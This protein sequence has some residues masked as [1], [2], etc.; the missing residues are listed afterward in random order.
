MSQ[1]GSP[2]SISSRRMAMPVHSVSSHR[3]VF[4]SAQFITVQCARFVEMTREWQRR[5]RDRRELGELSY[6][7]IKDFGDAADAEAER[8]KPF[9]KA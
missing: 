6:R 1:S 4:A 5:V 8:T 2:I 7:D 3:L 9:W